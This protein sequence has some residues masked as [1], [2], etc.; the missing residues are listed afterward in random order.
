MWP[1]RMSPRRWTVY[2]AQESGL[3]SDPIQGFNR[4]IA[5]L[6]YN[7]LQRYLM[8]Y[9]YN[10][11]WYMFWYSFDLFSCIFLNF[12]EHTYSGI[13]LKFKCFLSKH[14]AFVDTQAP[15]VCRCWISMAMKWG[16]D[17]GAC[18]PPRQAFIRIGSVCCRRRTQH[19]H[20]ASNKCIKS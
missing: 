5:G 6:I 9:L 7:T 14:L 11:L 8:L 1:K 15:L 13:G 10:I 19:V 17:F 20:S 2:E 4:S 16:H 12:Y 18:P 3:R